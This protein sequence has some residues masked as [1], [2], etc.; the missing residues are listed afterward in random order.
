MVHHH[1]SKNLNAIAGASDEG[2]NT[3]V[4]PVT[5]EATVMPA[6]IASGK[7]HGGITAPTPSGT[8]SRWFCSPGI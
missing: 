1:I 6:M 2:F 7:F 5:T 8:Y 3:T 4:L